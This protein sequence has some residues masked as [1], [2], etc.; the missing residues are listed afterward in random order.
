MI[1][2]FLAGITLALVVVRLNFGYLVD[3]ER[4][5]RRYQLVSPRIFT[6]K[7][8]DLI[9]NFATLRKDI[10]TVLA[11]S[12]AEDYS[13]Y[14]EYLPTGTSIKVNQ[15][16]RLVGASLLKVPLVMNLYEAAEKGQADLSQKVT[17]TE[18]DINKGSGD[19]WRRGVGARL[20]LKEAARQA[21]V[22][23]DN[24]A[25]N[26]LVRNASN[27]FDIFTNS[28]DALDITL[29]T[30]EDAETAVSAQEYASV[31][32]CL[33]LS[34]FINKQHSNQ[35]LEWLSQSTSPARIT[36]GVPKGIK[37][38]HKYGTAGGKSESDCGI[39]Y[40]PNRPYL[41]CM[42]V[43]ADSETA[44]QLMSRLSAQVYGYVTTIDDTRH[45]TA[46]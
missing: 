17:I 26:L 20:D 22:E 31:M 7:Q 13:F 3:Q 21:L 8:N 6:T 46:R 30:N 33:Y 39:V 25:V 45:T 16:N 28:I 5:Q 41:L 18:S 32:K 12:K 15:D 43:K 38:A 19:L 37:V 10:R 36:A 23:S 1:F 2:A 34:C 24:T 14:F 11:E 40:A 42:L 4:E 29:T 9:V 27:D 35:I 44:T